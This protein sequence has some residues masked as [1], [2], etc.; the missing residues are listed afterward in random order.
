MKVIAD[1]VAQAGGRLCGISWRSGNK[2]MGASRSLGLAD[3][4]PVL[5]LPGFSF[6][7]LQYGEVAADIAALRERLG[8]NVQ[9]AMGVDVF[10]DIDG[11]LALIDLCDVVLTIDNVTAH[12]AGAL[13][14]ASIVLVPTGRGRYWY[15][16]GEERSIW[17]PSLKL[18]YQEEVG[19]WGPGIASAAASL[20]Q[21]SGRV[22]SIG[23]PNP[24]GPALGRRRRLPSPRRSTWPPR[25]NAA[26]PPDILR[27]DEKNIREHSIF[28][29]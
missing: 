11:L 29:V 8:V 10:H 25:A 23:R 28:N 6:V 24:I 1:G 26:A 17:Y 22:G 14:K 15:W 3:L 9:Q 4:A 19:A 21:H 2:R 18:V 5:T 20:P 16:G 27:V 12:L 7:N 13:G